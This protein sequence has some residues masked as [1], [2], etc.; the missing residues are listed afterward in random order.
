[1]QSEKTSVEKTEIEKSTASLFERSF[2]AFI[3]RYVEPKIPQGIQPNQITFVG[4]GFGMLAAIALYLT[5]VNR[6]WAWVAVVSLIL[7][8]FAD[9]LDGAVARARSLTSQRGFLLD[10]L[11]DQLIFVALFLSVGFSNYALLPIAV[12]GAIVA[13]LH[14]ILELYWIHLK[15]KFPL[16]LLGPIEVRATAMVL[17]I[18]TFFWDGSV[19][20]LREIPFGWFDVVN[21]IAL[22]LSFTEFCSSALK[23]YQELDG[24][25][26][27][28]S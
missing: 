19:L 1:M 2:D 24:P 12:M 28:P 7:N 3:V 6:D 11:L 26:G 27:E 21:A 23:L 22:P 8:T 16:P 9:S 17:I 18:L 15:N 4:F 10:H 13:N 14:L 20:T 25:K 5:G